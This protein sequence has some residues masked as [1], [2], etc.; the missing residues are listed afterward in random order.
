MSTTNTQYAATK[1]RPLMAFGVSPP[2]C[3]VNDVNA[4]QKLSTSVKFLRVPHGTVFYSQ[5]TEK[6][7]AHLSTSSTFDFFNKKKLVFE[8][9]LC[10]VRPGS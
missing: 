4:N 6:I 8:Y 2:P 7:I 9:L 5:Q 1:T 10:F 3:G